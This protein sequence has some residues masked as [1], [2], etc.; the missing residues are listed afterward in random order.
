VS[1]RALVLALISLLPL[2]AC[3][4]D[5]PP[6]A[7]PDAGDGCAHL[8][9]RPIAK[10]GLDDDECSPRCACAGETFEP[11]EYDAT[12]IQSL[13]DDY[14]LETPFAPLASDPYE[15]APPPE[16]TAD[17]VCAVLLTGDPG[18]H[19][20]AYRLVTYP[21]MKAAEAA[22]AHPTHYGH[23]GV[24]S[25]LDNLAVY[26][27]ENDLSSPVRACAF[28]TSADGGDGVLDCLRAI[29]FDLPCAQ[30]WAFNTEHTREECLDTCLE[31][32][33]SP[34]NSP[35]G[36]LNP[37]LACDEEKS[38]AVFKAVAG[39][40]RRNSGLPNAICRPCAE[41]RPL[42]HAY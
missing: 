21:S 20:R 40:T 11:P 28:A 10:T 17:A 16:D 41:V 34:Y 1:R 38:G 39:R 18:A 37:C 24:C 29:G 33:T 6:A 5:S 30:I 32:F 8:F 23:C 9:G 22:G 4:A 2:A 12:F 25:T 42:V 15:A 36:G 19:P 14:V 35:D 27:R 26:M 7:G 31:N 3:K 13:V